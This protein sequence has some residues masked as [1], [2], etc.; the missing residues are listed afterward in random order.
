[1]KF[2]FPEKLFSEGG[3]FGLVAVERHCGYVRI[4]KLILL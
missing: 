3:F 4:I 2:V 1:V